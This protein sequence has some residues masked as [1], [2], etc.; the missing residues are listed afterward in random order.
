[1][2]LKLQ[3]YDKDNIPASIIEKVRPFAKNPEFTPAK[4]AKASKAAEGFVRWVLSMEIYDRVA[5]QVLPKRNALAQAQKSLQAASEQLAAKKAQLQEVQDL[6]DDLNAQFELVN[7]KKKSL[8]QQVSECSDRLDRAEKLLGGLANE[9]GRW[10]ERAQQL[11]LDFVNVSGNILVSSGVIAYLGVF[12]SLYRDTCV[13]HWVALLQSKNLA[14]DANFSLAKVLGD[15]V[16]IRQWGIQFLP[17][18]AFAIDN[19]LIATKSARYPL[20][21]DPQGQA[22]RWIKALEDDKTTL[23]V[24]KQTDDQ[25]IRTLSTCLQVGLPILIENVGESID[26]VLDSVL[27]KQVFKSGVRQ[28]IRLGSEVLAY[29]D[30]FR[31][32]ITTKLHN[33][34]YPPET[35]TSQ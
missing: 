1:M 13:K 11:S 15:A 14:C 2:F 18:S 24:V 23:K 29:D 33:P 35:S 8:E 7:Q 6:L 22:N 9:K 5:S 25:F 30:N 17:I 16:Q 28:M 4:V 3:K 27:L 20:F 12:T 21:I 34:H 26:N 32:Y 10:Q 31:L 19:A